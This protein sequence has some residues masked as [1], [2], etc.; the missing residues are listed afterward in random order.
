M[1]KPSFF[2]WVPAA[3]TLA[4][5]AL[6]I[7]LRL[8]NRRFVTVEVQRISLDVE[9]AARTGRRVTVQSIFN[10][11]PQDA[12]EKVQT[13]GLLAQISHPILQFSMPAGQALP[14]VFQEK[15]TLPLRLSG[16][17]WIPLGKHSITIEA[18]DP[19]KREIVSHEQGQI[20]QV[21]RH[22]ISVVPY[23]KDQS[24]YTDQVDLYAG[25]LTDAVAAFARLFYMYRQSRWQQLYSNPRKPAK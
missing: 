3:V 23:G 13:P 16:L 5:G 1:K 24:L 8:W 4:A 17:G 6:L 15:K 18:I 12:W 20:A 10:L 7:S 22:H 11:R 19:L 21:W 2:V 25:P 14:E 9:G